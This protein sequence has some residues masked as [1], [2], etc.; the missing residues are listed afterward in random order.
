MT[1]ENVYRLLCA[2]MWMMEGPLI[3]LFLRAM[4]APS[5]NTPGRKAVLGF[6][7]LAHI[8]GSFIHYFVP[9]HFFMAI[10]NIALVASTFFAA[11]W[12]FQGRLTKKLFAVSLLMVTPAIADMVT[13]ATHLLMY[14]YAI[15]F[16]PTDL[17]VH[18]LLIST[19]TLTM[20]IALQGLV[21]ILWCRFI[22]Q[23]RI[24][25]YTVYLGAFLL[26]GISMV[27]SSLWPSQDSGTMFIFVYLCVFLALCCGIF[28]L[29]NQV[30]KAQ[31]QNELEEVRRLSELERVHYKAMETRQEEL[32]KIRHDY[33]NVLTSAL[34][35]MKNDDTP[36]AAQLLTQLTQRM[37]EPEETCYCALPVVNGV[38]AEKQ[39]Q[40]EKAGIGFHVELSLPEGPGLT[41]PDLC[42]ALSHLVD[43]AAEACRPETAV[44]LTCRAVQGY[45]VIKC[46]APSHPGKWDSTARPILEGI[47]GRFHGDFFTE[48]RSQ[49]F[50]AQLSLLLPTPT[51][52]R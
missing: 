5:P 20:G 16:G 9:S 22:K 38:L 40:L 25:S 42:S 17:D 34:H 48:Y 33:S 12:C 19:A 24:L 29:V 27:A 50:T 21:C 13:A 39:R 8:V 45:L 36:E 18:A 26:L 15:T 14:G 23:N 47:A 37:A 32:A 52:A 30:E 44:S 7:C 4:L 35:L 1:L 43:L 46:S 6:M 2:L 10:Q 3:I 41:E 49:T 11:V 31:I 28:V 51:E